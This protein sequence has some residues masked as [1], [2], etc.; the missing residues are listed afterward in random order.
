[1]DKSADTVAEDEA[2]TLRHISGNVGTETLIET[3][4]D[5]L[6]EAEAVRRLGM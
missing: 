4:A 6:G 2:E 1:M 5:T 3:L